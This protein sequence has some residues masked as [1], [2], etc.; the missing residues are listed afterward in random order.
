M[1]QC[2]WHSGVADSETLFEGLSGEY[3]DVVCLSLRQH[4]ERH[5]ETGFAEDVAID[6]LYR[7]VLGAV[8]GSD[9]SACLS[10]SSLQRTGVHVLAP[11]YL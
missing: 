1:D 7:L 3:V 10:Y 8:G 11:R 2:V 6:K 5:A 9:L 4:R